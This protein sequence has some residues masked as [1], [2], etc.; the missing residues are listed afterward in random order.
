MVPASILAAS[1]QSACMTSAPDQTCQVQGSQYLEANITDKQVCELFQGHLS[2]AL[3][4]VNNGKKLSISLK[5]LKS[6]TIDAYVTND[7]GASV[8][9][10]GS[11]SIDVMDRALEIGD[12]ERLAQAVAQAMTMQINQS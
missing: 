7:S 5:I 4:D 6:G 1:L 12:V 3:G 8:T 10:H 11:V 2:S 9:P